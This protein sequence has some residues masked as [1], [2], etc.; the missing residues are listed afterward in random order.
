MR[1]SKRA[2]SRASPTL[3]TAFSIGAQVT[4]GSTAQAVVAVDLQVGRD[5]VEQADLTAFDL[6]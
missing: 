3:A 4:V 2:A 6:R 5:R 1:P